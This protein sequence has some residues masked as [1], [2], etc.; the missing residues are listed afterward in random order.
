MIS[1]SNPSSLILD[2]LT[3]KSL[4]C[5]FRILQYWF[6]S[7]PSLVHKYNYN[8]SLSQAVLDN[9][10]F[11]LNDNGILISI[12]VN[13]NLFKVIVSHRLLVAL[14]CV[15]FMLNIFTSTLLLSVLILCCTLS[16]S[17]SFLGILCWYIISVSS[18]SKC[19]LL[20]MLLL[21]SSSE[22]TVSRVTVV[23]CRG[24]WLYVCSDP[25][26]FSLRC[27]QWRFCVFAVLTHSGHFIG[28]MTLREAC[29]FV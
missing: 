19:W 6:S 16:V 11:C 18:R 15:P 8:C 27:K 23:L 5:L 26:H 24:F 13:D 10:V 3:G 25:P 9:Q 12:G 4:R 7:S 28:L 29:G 14:S 1:S 21:N 22:G 20:L 2:V 17:L